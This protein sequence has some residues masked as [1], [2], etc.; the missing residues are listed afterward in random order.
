MR[1][2]ISVVMAMLTPLVALAVVPSSAGPEK[3]AFPANYKDHVLY[4]TVDRYDNMQY[5]E[6]YDTPDAVK[7]AREG[8]PIPSGTVPTLVQVEG[9]GRRC[10]QPDQG[11]QRPI[12]QRR[13]RRDHRDGE[14]DGL[15]YGVPGRHPERRVGVLGVHGGSEVQRQGELQGVLPVPHAQR[16]ARFCDLAGQARRAGAGWFRRDEDEPQ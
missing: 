7:A 8:K 5:R 9:A 10:R 3:I 15:R 12:R 6:L 4:A 14:A 2:K 13:P 1:N 16:E 11:R